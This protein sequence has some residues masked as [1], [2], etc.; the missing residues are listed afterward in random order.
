MKSNAP[1][2]GN[3]YL[4]YAFGGLRLHYFNFVGVV[5]YRIQLATVNSYV[6]AHIS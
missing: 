2:I 6:V 1:A 4:S 3:I 5:D